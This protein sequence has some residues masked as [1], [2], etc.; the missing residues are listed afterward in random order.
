M[1]NADEVQAIAR[2][3]AQALDDYPIVA[4]MPKSPRLA[5]KGQDLHVDV[6]PT[7]T[8]SRAADRELEDVK[9]E[10]DEVKDSPG[11]P[12]EGQIQDE[13]PTESRERARS[14]SPIRGQLLEAWNRTGTTGRG[15]EIL[16]RD[17]EETKIALSEEDVSLLSFLADERMSTNL[18]Y[19]RMR[20]KK[21]A[22]R[23]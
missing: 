8:E 21:S 16:E 19:L 20:V 1:G 9:S 15:R 12:N 4:F 2:R 14:R 18:L 11:G 13:Q 10:Q 5:E 17:A 22:G 23:P 3:R 7:P 6:V